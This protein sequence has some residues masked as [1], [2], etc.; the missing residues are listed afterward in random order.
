MKI[1]SLLI[2]VAV[3]NCTVGKSFA[4]NGFTVKAE[5][6]NSYVQDSLKEGKWI[7]YLDSLLKPI[8]KNNAKYYRLAVYHHGKENEIVRLYSLTDS[9]ILETAMSD[10]EKNGI[11]KYFYTVGSQYINDTVS[12]YIQEIS[13]LHSKRNGFFKLYKDGVLLMEDLYK[14]DKRNGLSKS[15]WTDG[16]ISKESTYSNDT[17]DGL[18]RDYYAGGSKLHKERMYKNGK[19]NGISKE[20]DL[21]GILMETI[22]YKDDLADGIRTRYKDNKLH[23]T[24]EYKNGLR[25]GVT[26]YYYENGTIGSKTFFK[27]DLEDGM[28]ETYYKNGNVSTSGFYKK[29][30]IDGVMKEYYENKKIKKETAYFHGYKHGIEKCYHPNGSLKSVATFYLDRKNGI[31]KIYNAKGTL[32]SSLNYKNGYEDN[33]NKPLPPKPLQPGK[34]DVKAGD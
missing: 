15:Y 9:L 1:I 12:H 10:G 28:F 5:A 17:L 11:E 18:E 24:A 19:L 23:I 3:L 26:K 6:K 21:D 29:G 20:Y 22:T 8:E 27:D 14:Q 31:E 32:I 4:Q 2:F 25:N 33:T 7:E 30:E 16:Q 13:Y 34:R